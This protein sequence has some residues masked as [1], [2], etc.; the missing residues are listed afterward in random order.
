MQGND[1]RV[2]RHGKKFI[3]Q[4]RSMAMKKFKTFLAEALKPTMRFGGATFKLERDK[5]TIT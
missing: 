2:R 5:G 4:M 1:T 3:L